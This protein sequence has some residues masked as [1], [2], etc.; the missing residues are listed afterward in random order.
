MA[1][2]IKI[3]HFESDG[4]IIYLP[5]GFVPDLVLLFAK[6]A[7]SGS[8]IKYIWFREMESHDSL[9][10]WIDTPNAAPA[11]IA[12]GSGLATYDSS[13]EVPTIEEWTQ[14]R[15]NAAT[16]RSV[17]AHG[18]YI[19]CTTSGVDA[20]G[21]PMDRSAIFECVVDGNGAA[22]EPAWPRVVGE[23]VIDN[24]TQ[25][26]R[27]NDVVLRRGGYQGFRLAAAMTGLA[28]GNE[29]YFIAI[30]SGG[31]VIDFGDVDSW[32]GGIEGA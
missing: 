21:N 27:V 6:G 17:T 29:G 18:T 14:A 11:Q 30:A 12:A 3:G 2:Q 31:N 26:E 13:L 19:K 23:V 28:N 8:L 4:A 16:A 7:A 15:S 10:G 32:A 25:W 24:T 1:N 20:L 5:I 22:T 9:D